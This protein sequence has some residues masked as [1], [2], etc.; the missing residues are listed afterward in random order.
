MLEARAITKTYEAKPL[1]K[2]VSFTLGGGETLCL[3]GSSGSGKSTLLRIIA[4]LEVAEGGSVLWEGRDLADVPSHK[5]N[6][7]LMFQDY[8]LFPHRSVQDNVAFGLRMQ[9]RT[10]S[11]IDR[12][13]RAALEQVNMASFG[14]RR[15]TDLSGG[16]QQRVAL[17]RALAPRPR[18]LMLDEPLGALDRALR[19]QLLDELRRLLHATE[20]PAIYVTHDQEEAFTLADRVALLHAGR[21]VQIG[22]SQEVYQ[23]PASPWVA[24]FLG[25]TNLLSGTVIDTQPLF[26]STPL[27]GFAASWASEQAGRPRSGQKVT[28]LIPQREDCGTGMLVRGRVVDVLYRGDGFHARVVTEGEFS[29]DFQLSRPVEVHEEVE[30]SLQTGGILAWPEEMH[31]DE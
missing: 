11:E 31:A 9:G 2:G 27:G 19:E 7:G 23:R 17:A 6:F 4:G 5:R 20:I 26:V 16:E 22:S 1:L 8:A 28:V 25:Q 21:L 13:V 29:L 18:L 24:R 30:I 14:A 10:R 3:L 12:Q 15:V